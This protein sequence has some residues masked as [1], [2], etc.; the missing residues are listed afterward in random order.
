MAKNKIRAIFCDHG[1][2]VLRFCGRDERLWQMARLAN[3]KRF[4]TPGNSL[5]PSEPYNFF[6]MALES[7]G[8]LDLSEP[9]EDTAWKLD[10]GKTTQ[11]DLYRGFLSAA[12]CDKQTFPPER[13][14][15]AYSADLVAIH[16]V[17]DLLQKLQSQGL[18]VIAATNGDTWS[19]DIVY[20]QTDFVFDGV[21]MSWQVG[22]KK[23]HEK[24]FAACMQAGR[25][26]LRGGSLSFPEC[27]LLDDLAENCSGFRA[28]G[29]HAIRF[30][31]SKNLPTLKWEIAKL[32]HELRAYGLP[33]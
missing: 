24:F 8:I 25:D 32:R 3:P 12:G 23:P 29:G 1:N 30:K 20:R 16:P 21:V 10:T 11:A 6:V 9:G 28:L 14:W 22:H 7:C 26:A 2:V 17:C 31:A 15:M 18:P 33:E 4:G 5:R 19:A 13:F 27:L